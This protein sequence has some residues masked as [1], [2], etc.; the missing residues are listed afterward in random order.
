M[1]RHK[2]RHKENRIGTSKLG[3]DMIAVLRGTSVAA[4]LDKG[5]SKVKYT[6]PQLRRR[7]SSIHDSDRSDNAIASFTASLPLAEAD[8]RCTDAAPCHLRRIAIITVAPPPPLLTCSMPAACSYSLRAA[9]PSSP[10][11]GARCLSLL[12]RLLDPS[13]PRC[14][15]PPVARAA[16]P[17]LAVPP[18]P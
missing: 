6:S 11:R 18:S 2:C 3:L 14:R 13:L 15:W 16:S 5:K 12:A 10:P 9:L 8:A 17:D 4:A 1:G 7:H